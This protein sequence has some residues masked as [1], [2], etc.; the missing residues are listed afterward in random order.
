MLEEGAFADP[1]PEVAFG[2][3]TLA[4][5]PLGQIGYTPG[6]A[7]AAV[8]HF[9]IA[10]TGTQTHGAQPHQG[11]DPIVLASQVIAAFQ[12]IVARSLDPLQPAVVTVGMVHGGERFNII[13]AEVR[14]EGTVRSYSPEVRDTVERRMREILDGLTAAAG[15]RFELDY[16]RGT[17]ATINDVEL[18]RRMLPTIR[19]LL[20]DDVVELPPTMGGEDFAYFANT[21][22]GFFYRLG[23]LAPGTTS[24]PHHSPTFRADDGSVPVGIRVM[25]NLIVDYLLSAAAE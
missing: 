9:K 16:V 11:V 18:T 3:H 12:T 1:K 8:D 24:G 15:A 19:A 2:L 6:P 14:M 20:G 4:D 25:S 7:L 23:T 5:L 21:V 10:L 22:P 13:P 17:P